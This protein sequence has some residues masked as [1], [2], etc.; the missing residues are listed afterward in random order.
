MCYFRLGIVKR[1]NELRHDEIRWEEN[2]KIGKYRDEI[3]H[4]DKVKLG[5]LGRMT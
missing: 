4:H 2:H 3:I 1:Y 5:G